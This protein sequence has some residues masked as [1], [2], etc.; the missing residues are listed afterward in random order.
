M[1]RDIV[2]EQNSMFSVGIIE[3]KFKSPNVFQKPSFYGTRKSDWGILKEF[4]TYTVR[5][6]SQEEP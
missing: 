2:L 3:Y 4:D 1:F 6:L 5:H